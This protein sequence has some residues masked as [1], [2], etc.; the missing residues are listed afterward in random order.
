MSA[1]SLETRIARL[2]EQLTKRQQATLGLLIRAAIER[3]PE[4]IEELARCDPES[5]LYVLMAR[6]TERSARLLREQQLLRFNPP[7]D[8]SAAN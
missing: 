1:R 5:E 7:G 6:D 4:A 2:E 8:A 3:D